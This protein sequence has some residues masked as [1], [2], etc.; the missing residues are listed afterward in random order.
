M[1]SPIALAITAGVFG[2]LAAIASQ[3]AYL[4]GRRGERPTYFGGQP[5]SPDVSAESTRDDGVRERTGKRS[6]LYQMAT[7]AF[8]VAT[9][10][11][12]L[13]V[14]LQ[15]PFRSVIALVGFAIGAGLPLYRSRQWLQEDRRIIAQTE[16]YVMMGQGLKTLPVDQQRQNFAEQHPKLARWL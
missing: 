4:E 9:A 16:Y 10:L 11:V 5:I 3:L 2:V 7:S 8:V 6:D 15:G 1:I 12:G 14:E 13:S